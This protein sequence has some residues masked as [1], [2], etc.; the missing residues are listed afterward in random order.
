MKGTGAGVVGGGLPRNFI[1]QDTYQ[2][3]YSGEAK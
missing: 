2:S 1:G 3:G